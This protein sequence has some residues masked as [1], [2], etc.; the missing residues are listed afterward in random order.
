M[1]A[2][3]PVCKN[4]VAGPW[5]TPSVCMDRMKA[6]SSTGD[7]NV[8]YVPYMSQPQWPGLALEQSVQ[9]TITDVAVPG[10]LGG[11][12]ELLWNGIE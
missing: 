8:A 6:M 11:F 7:L 4:K 3:D 1:K 5:A 2:V 12:L 9:V 10:V